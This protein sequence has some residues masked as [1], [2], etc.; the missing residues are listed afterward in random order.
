MSVHRSYFQHAIYLVGRL[1][2]LLTA[3]CSKWIFHVLGRFVIIVR[4][5]RY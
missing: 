1:Q 5:Q 4:V 3:L 2:P